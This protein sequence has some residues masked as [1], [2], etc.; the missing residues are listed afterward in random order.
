M[1]TSG[2]RTPTAHPA[3]LEYLGRKAVVTAS[4][5]PAFVGLTGLVVDET[6]NTFVLELD[7]GRRVRVPKAGQ[8]FAID[9]LASEVDGGA[10]GHRPEDRIKKAR[11]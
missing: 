8:R 4:A 7:D 5:H 1:P 9:G 3:Q 6:K 2:R 11:R 10:I